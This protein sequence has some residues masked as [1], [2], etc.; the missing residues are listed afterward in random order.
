MRPNWEAFQAIM[1]SSYL[2]P[3]VLDSK[4][5]YLS[6]FL[7]T[8]YRYGDEGL[9]VALRQDF[10]RHGHPVILERLEHNL[11]IPLSKYELVEHSPTDMARVHSIFAVL[12]HYYNFLALAITACHIDLGDQ[13][14]APLERIIKLLL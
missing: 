10:V 14:N 12:K 7:R 5:R 4:V 8:L 1:G 3:E 6:V 11:L 13:A 2:S 9:R